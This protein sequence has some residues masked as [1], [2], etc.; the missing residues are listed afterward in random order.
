MPVSYQLSDEALKI[1]NT[2]RIRRELM[3]ILEVTEFTIARYIQKNN[4]IL[5]LYAV[6]ELITKESGLTIDQILKANKT[7]E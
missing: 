5:T 6:I 1:I 3:D 7:S 4:P 2:P